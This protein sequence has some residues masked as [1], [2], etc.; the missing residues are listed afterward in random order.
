LLPASTQYGRLHRGESSRRRDGAV[1]LLQRVDHRLV[2]LGDVAEP[3]L[4]AR[5]DG[6]LERPVVHQLLE[7]RAGPWR[8]DQPDHAVLVGRQGLLQHGPEVA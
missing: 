7:S 8:V 3:P 4:E 5:V 2:P 6:D 1:R